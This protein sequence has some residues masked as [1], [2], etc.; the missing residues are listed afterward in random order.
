MGLARP[1]DLCDAALDCLAETWSTDPVV[2]REHGVRLYVKFRG[3]VFF[4][5]SDRRLSVSLRTRVATK[6][7]VFYTLLLSVPVTVRCTF[8]K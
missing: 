2:L 3:D 4:I 7:N 8:L 6:G 1:G 5:G